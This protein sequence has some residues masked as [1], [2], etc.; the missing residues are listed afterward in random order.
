MGI[1]KM[2]LTLLRCSSALAVMCA[3]GWVA[4]AYA[5]QAVS[6]PGLRLDLGTGYNSSSMLGTVGGSYVI[7]LSTSLGAQ[8]DAIGGAARSNA[9]IGAAGH[10]FW[11]DPQSGSLGAYGSYLYGAGRPSN[12]NSDMHD[13]KAGIEGSYLVGNFSLQS[14]AGIEWNNFGSNFKRN[15]SYAFDDT[16]FNWYATNK[17]KLNIGNR[18]TA[19]RSQVV[20]GADYYTV[21]GTTPSSLFVDSAYGGRNKVNDADNGFKI[22]AG[23]H[24]YFD[25][26]SA[27]TSPLLNDTQG[28]MPDYLGS[29]ATDLPKERK[30]GASDY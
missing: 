19:N 18:Y 23:V 20:G 29:D 26:G 15:T 30:F 12:I 24:F 22:T 27:N 2:R 8:V 21:F 14:V 9:M 4:P 17:L 25:G 11:R 5:Q 6:A 16:R 7:P 13:A 10:L 3:A 28:Y 1:N